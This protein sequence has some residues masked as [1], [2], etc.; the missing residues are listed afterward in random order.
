MPAIIAEPD[1]QAL[2]DMLCDVDGPGRREAAGR[3]GRIPSTRG[4]QP[5]PPG[6][7]WSCQKLGFGDPLPAVPLRAHVLEEPSQFQ[8]L[9]CRCGLLSRHCERYRVGGCALLCRC[10]PLLCRC[11]LLSR[12]CQRYCVGGCVWWHRTIAAIV[13]RNGRIDPVQFGGSICHSPCAFLVAEILPVL[14]A[15]NT[16]DLLMP[17]AAAA[18]PSV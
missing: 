11:G 6:L 14:M 9:F 10:G 17:D 7:W 3:L 4:A 15:R 12:L 13:R 2:F 5:L 16:V 8:S 1:S 18:V